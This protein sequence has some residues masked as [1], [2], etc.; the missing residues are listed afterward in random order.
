[1]SYDALL[2][3]FKTRRSCRSFAE[4]DVPEGMMQKI[5]QA[6]LWTPSCHNSQGS[7]AIRLTSP[8]IK[9]KLVE[10]TKQ[11][12]HIDFDPFYG[13]KEIV[14]V[15][16]TSKQ[17]DLALLDG[18]M[19]VYN[20]ML[21]AETLNLGSCW[22]NTAQYE[23]QLE[24]SVH[25]QIV[26]RLNLPKCYGVGYLALGYPNLEAIGGKLELQRKPNRIFQV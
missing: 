21:A 3:F 16:N 12:M 17:A 10:N 2:A 23:D 20:M 22:I 19:T 7:I 8:D 24:D 9:A 15:F 25:E 26:E 5:M 13:A 6:G 1:M 4:K 18:S 14:A 11:M